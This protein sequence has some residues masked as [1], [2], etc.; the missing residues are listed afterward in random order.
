MLGT[1]AYLIQLVEVCNGEETCSYFFEFQ[2]NDREFSF[3][4]YNYILYLINYSPCIFK[5]TICSKPSSVA[6]EQNSYRG[7][8]LV[9]KANAFWPNAVAG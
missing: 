9:A 7:V 4:V 2:T 8:T 5:E 6:V 1:H 3:Y